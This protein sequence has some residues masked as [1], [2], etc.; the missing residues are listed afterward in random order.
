MGTKLIDV[1]RKEVKRT[2][3]LTISRKRAAVDRGYYQDEF[4][5]VFGEDYN[6][7][8]LM[9]LTYVVRVSS[10]RMIADLFIESFNGQPV[11]FVNLGGGLDTLCFYLL[12]KHP[13]VICFDTDLEGQLKLKCELM[14][15]HKIFTDLI[16]DLK[17]ENGFYTS[18]RYKVVGQEG[19]FAKNFVQKYKEHSLIIS[20]FQRY[21]TLEDN[22]R[23]YKDLGWEQVSATRAT[24]LW[25]LLPE[26]ERK[27]VLAIQ[28]FNEIEGLGVHY[29]YGLCCVASN[30]YNHPAVYK[31]IFTDKP[32]TNEE[33]ELYLKDHDYYLKVTSPSFNKEFFDKFFSELWVQRS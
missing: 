27:R 17:L 23:R 1:D 20:S 15:G 5:H 33:S 32:D 26:S 31:H 18:A 29:G 28:S 7:T 14:S 30:R 8:P 13:N 25:N 16:P 4:V 19:Y 24:N 21:K 22:I 11:Q 9:S 12:K 10:T 3:K 6:Q 2:G